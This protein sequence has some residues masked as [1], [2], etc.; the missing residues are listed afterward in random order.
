MTSLEERAEEILAYLKRYTHKDGYAFAKDATA[1]IADQARRIEELEDK[2]SC[3]E[4]SP[5][6]FKQMMED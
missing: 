1:V 6:A 4:M 3:M 2:L 5:E